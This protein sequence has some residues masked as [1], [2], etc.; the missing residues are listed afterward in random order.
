VITRDLA[1]LMF[2]YIALQ[3]MTK[4]DIPGVGVIFILPLDTIFVCFLNLS[5]TLFIS[6][7]RL[8]KQM[9]IRCNMRIF[10]DYLA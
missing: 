1:I 8:P 2:I 9:S 4:S 10:Q 6:F 3:N 7:V 5:F